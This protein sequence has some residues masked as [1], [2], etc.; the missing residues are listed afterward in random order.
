MSSKY[1]QTQESI[2]AYIKAAEGVNSRA[3]IAEFKKHLNEGDKILE[4]GS[5]PGTDWEFLNQT[6]E[7]VG[8]DYSQAFIDHLEK[9][10]PNGD[11]QLLDAVSLSIDQKFDGIY[12][13]KVLH[14][15]TDEELINSTQKQA[16]TLNPKG[17]LCHSF[18]NGNG[19]EY[20]KDMFVNYH[21]QEEIESLFNPYFDILQLKT[22]EEFESED[23]LVLIAQKKL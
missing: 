17:I 1:Y 5:G 19:D 20:F 2:K 7:V 16:E 8:S 21:D 15:L 6:H 23:S 22:Y 12:S 4:L 10:F 9:R 14:H 18:W 11:F 13:N 3:L